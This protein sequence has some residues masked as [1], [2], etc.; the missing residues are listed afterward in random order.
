MG[1]GKRSPLNFVH[2]RLSILVFLQHQWWL[3][4]QCVTFMAFFFI[5]IKWSPVFHLFLLHLSFPSHVA[6]CCPVELDRT[7]PTLDSKQHESHSDLKCHYRHKAFPAWFPPQ[8]YPFR[9]F[10]LDNL[11]DF[12]NVWHHIRKG[13]EAVRSAWL[14]FKYSNYNRR[15]MLWYFP[16]PTHKLKGDCV[17]SSTS[18]FP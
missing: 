2:P 4:V 16:I 8:P 14:L 11:S 17:W 12:E 18:L 9:Y 15:R 10:L 7:L 13:G 1:Q 6:S 3:Y 5:L